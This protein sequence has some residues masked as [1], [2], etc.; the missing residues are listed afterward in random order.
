MANILRGEWSILNTMGQEAEPVPHCMQCLI[1]S[2][3]GIEDIS[4]KNLVS[5]SIEVSI[6]F[7][8]VCVRKKLKKHLLL[9][10]SLYLDFIKKH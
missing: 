2:P 4:S 7:F 8:L 1:F 9:N 10:Y 6:V 5:S 3:P